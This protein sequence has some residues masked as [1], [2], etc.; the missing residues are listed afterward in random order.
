MTTRTISLG[1]LL[2]LAA[3]TPAAN[4]K[5]EL[6]QH[7]GAFLKE[8]TKGSEKL[9]AT[10][11]TPS[12]VFVH[13]NGGKLSRMRFLDATKK[14]DA[15]VEDEEFSFTLSNVRQSGNT[16]RGILEV[17]TTGVTYGAKGDAHKIMVNERS[18]IVWKRVNG[19]WLADSIQVDRVR[20]KID[21]KVVAD[22]RRTG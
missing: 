8:E 4:L 14:R 13:V 2:L 20:Q 16:A 9:A 7:I 21:G 17:V 15:L 10:H 1:S 19:K 12:F 22:Q 18:E 6:T 11:F 3:T 5:Q